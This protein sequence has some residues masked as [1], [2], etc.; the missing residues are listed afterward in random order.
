M[1]SARDRLSLLLEALLWAAVLVWLV[2]LAFDIR[3][4]VKAYT[5]VCGA[6]SLHWAQG[7]PERA[8]PWRSILEFVLVGLL[9]WW[10]YIRARIKGGDPR[11]VDPQDHL[12]PSPNAPQ[13]S[14]RLAVRPRSVQYLPPH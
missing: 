1:V 2:Y 5:Q 11:T 7:C 13:P 8:L 6:D 9:V 14:D 3:A 4:G 10:P 12:P